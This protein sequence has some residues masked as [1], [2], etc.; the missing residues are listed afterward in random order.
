MILDILAFCLIFRLDFA[1]YESRLT[2][3]VVYGST[4]VKTSHS[5]VAYPLLV[6]VVELADTTDTRIKYV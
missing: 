5:V 4:I 3:Y 6:E 2:C 1:G